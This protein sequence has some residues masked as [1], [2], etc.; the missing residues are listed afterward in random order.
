MALRPVLPLLDYA[1][2]YK[3]ISQNLCENKNKPQLLCN[4]KCYVIKELLKS[5]KQSNKEN[6]K[7]SSADVFIIKD[8]LL[9]TLTLI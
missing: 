6:H 1:F 8:N 2:N 5:E 3:Y 9:F 7:I 4:G